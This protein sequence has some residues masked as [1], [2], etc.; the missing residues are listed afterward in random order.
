M[1]KRWFR[2]RKNEYYYRLAKIEGY[3]S[4]SAY[5]LLQISNKYHIL[6]RGGVVVDLGAAPGGWMQIARKLVGD[7]GYVLGVDLKPILDLNYTNVFSIIGDVEKFRGCDI[8][9]KLP[10]DADVVL[11]DLSPN[12]SG[13]WELDHTRQI[14]LAEKAFELAIEI[15]SS[16]GIF[17]VK[18]FHGKHLMEFVE[19]I[20]NDFRIIKIIKPKASRK[21]SSEIYIVALG[22]K[23]KHQ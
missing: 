13:T 18:A 1:T 21:K 20:K 16:D 8:L 5:K 22:F 17:L 23:A 14:G 6:K 19:K 3:R 2:E 9:E 12:V 11:S 15:L 10:R 4:R 7:K